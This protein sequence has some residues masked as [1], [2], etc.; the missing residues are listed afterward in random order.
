MRMS[1]GL[2]LSR[3]AASSGG[4]GPSN[5]PPVITGVPTISGTPE[6]GNTLTAS[7]ASVTGTPT[8][9]RTWQWIRNG[10]DIPGATTSTYLLTTDDYG[11]AIAVE[12]IETNSEDVATATSLETNIAAF[13]PADL[14][15]GTELGG[16]WDMSQASSLW[17][18]TA[19]TTPVTATG[20]SVARVDDLSGNGNHLLQGTTA[21]QP[22]YQED[23][24]VKYIALDGSDDVLATGVVNNLMRRNTT[25]MVGIW[26][27]S[28]GSGTLYNSTLGASNG[29]TN[30]VEISI[31]TSVS[32]PRIATRGAALGIAAVAAPTGGTNSMLPDTYH[33]F[34]GRFRAT[35]QTLLVNG[36]G[37]T[38]TAH[39]WADG[40]TITAASIN[41]GVSA[42][43]RARRI[44]FALYITRDL[45]DA[46]FTLLNAWASAK[47]NP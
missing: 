30:F 42:W 32:G 20:Q 23:G 10:L 34:T 7:P 2:G 15:T 45:T 35:E 27:A 19:A 40:Q 16:F 18:D 29:A 26:Y 4:G 25:L 12:Q 17:Q 21:S 39:T 37:L 41:T 38:P 9:V 13:T 22:L 36:V 3:R 46:E 6:V 14:F 24:N 28:G 43:G 8:P 44:A 5:S 31:R 47:L 33:R 1:L 11:A